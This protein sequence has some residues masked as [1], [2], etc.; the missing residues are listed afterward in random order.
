MK[1][2]HT[3]AGDGSDA[4][5]EGSD[6]NE[7]KDNLPEQNLVTSLVDDVAEVR[8]EEN[9][10]DGGNHLHEGLDADD[11]DVDVGNGLV[12][13]GNEEKDDRRAHKDAAI[14]G[15]GDQV[16][17]PDEAAGM[18]E[19]R[20]KTAQK[21]IDVR[22]LVVLIPAGHAT[23]VE[24]AEECFQEDGDGELGPEQAEG[25]HGAENPYAEAESLAGDEGEQHDAKYQPRDDG[26]KEAHEL[27]ARQPL[28]PVIMQAHDV[29][30]EQHGCA[31]TQS[32]LG[33]EGQRQGGQ[34]HNTRTYA[35]ACFNKA[36]K[37][38]DGSDKNIVVREHGN[39]LWL[40]RGC[41]RAATIH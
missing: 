21:A 6:E 7:A 38:A 22:T 12:D 41:F 16:E 3:R 39:I 18:G 32:N 31:E 35:Y 5:R 14:R 11:V 9:H 4:Q 20:G 8:S 19:D 25:V 13:V 37:K 36:G 26:E 27:G 40:K 2:I 23:L 10:G 29:R 15:G 30:S 34:K 28:L 24:L 33:W 1:E 17:G